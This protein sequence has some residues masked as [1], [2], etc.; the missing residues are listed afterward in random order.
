MK[1]RVT[2]NPNAKIY[3]LLTQQDSIT[4]AKVYN[5]LHDLIYT[6]YVRELT[7]DTCIFAGDQ[8]VYNPFAEENFNNDNQN[9]GPSDI[10]H[11]ENNVLV[12]R[13]HMFNGD[14]VWKEPL[15]HGDTL[16]F[17]DFESFE[18]LP[19]IGA[20]KVIDYKVVAKPQATAYGIVKNISDT[21]IKMNIF[22]LEDNTLLRVSQYATLPHAVK[23]EYEGNQFYFY[24]SGRVK[25]KL[26]YDMS[27]QLAV[28][29]DFYESGKLMR[30]CSFAPS[31]LAL[32]A[33]YESGAIKQQLSDTHQIKYYLEDG[34]LVENAHSLDAQTKALIGY[35]SLPEFIGG[36]EELFRYL[37]EHV[38]YPKSAADNRIEGRVV[39]QF[40]VSED[41]TI[42][43]ITILQSSGDLSLDREA[44]RVIK[45]MPRWKP[46]QLDGKPIRVKYHIPVNFKL[47]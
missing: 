24:P 36:Q 9:N 21:L 32:E 30:K 27:H 16:Y 11:Y 46:G 47:K 35:E 2:D 18:N 13:K 3:A 39:C 45:E 28:R 17:S 40:I 26:I 31:A 22:S 37:S 43:N 6:L 8:F 34:T 14:M 12:Y 4:E 44:K 41:G 5:G 10:Y 29:I 33:Y 20:G 38:H 23:P 7:K 1:F 42:N 15:E 19:F 25:T